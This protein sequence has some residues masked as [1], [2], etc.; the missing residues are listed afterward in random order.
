VIAVGGDDAITFLEGI[1]EPG[2][3]RFLTGVDV[4]VATNLTL[5]ETT[6]GGILEEPDLDHLPVEL[7][8]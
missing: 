1:D 8:K 7:D 6:T 3:D 2:R 5:A 4:K